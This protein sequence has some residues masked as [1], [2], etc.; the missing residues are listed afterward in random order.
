LETSYAIELSDVAEK[1]YARIYENAQACLERGDESNSKVK[2]LRIVD[3]VLDRII[4]HDPFAPDRALAGSLSGIFRIKKGRV[5][6]CYIGSSR[7]RKIVILYISDTPRKEGDS[8]DPYQVL[9]RLMKSGKFD[10]ILGSLRSKK[11]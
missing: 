9:N 5:R 1:M 6:I 3:E 4:P 2:Q 7:T 10:Q 8:R 11:E